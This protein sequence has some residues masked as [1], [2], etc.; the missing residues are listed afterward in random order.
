[1][2]TLLFAALLVA[3]VPGGPPNPVADY[4]V[5]PGDV[6]SIT[7]LREPELTNK[8]S[9]AADG[10]LDFPWIGRVM[11]GGRTVRSIEEEISKRLLDGKYLIIRP[12]ISIQIQE[13]RSQFVYVQG[14]V[15]G[16]G[17]HSL[18]GVTTLQELLGK[19]I[20]KG[21]AGEE[22]VLYRR[23]GP[24]REGT[25]PIHDD[26]DPNVEVIRV[27]KA[28]LLSGRAAAIVLQHEDTIS[29]PKA[30]S[31]FISGEV[32]APAAYVLDGELN[33]LQV[34]TMA[35]GPTERG[36]INKTDRLTIVDGKQKWV[37]VKVTDIVRPGD[38]LRVGRKWF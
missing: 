28:D 3:Q 13:F 16:L 27:K 11:A 12:E 9:I 30:P 25:G 15:Q 20:V 34:I 5:G 29:V 21:T 24:H 7:V 26:K 6:L 38:T 35:G 32:K 17:M 19:V 33:V 37:R 10:T 4:V 18:T 1:M 36:D 31:V 8:F 14:E 2:K 22:I 23:K